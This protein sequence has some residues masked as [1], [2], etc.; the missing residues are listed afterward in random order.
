MRTVA[1]QV[2]I[3][4]KTRVTKYAELNKLSALEKVIIGFLMELT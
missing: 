3:N 4:D 1:N 2:K